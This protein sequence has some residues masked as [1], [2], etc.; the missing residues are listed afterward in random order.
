MADLRHEISIEAKPETILQAITTAAGLR[1]WWTT[2]VEAQPKEGSLAKFGFMNRAVIFT[3]KVERIHSE[4][5]EWTCVDGPADWIG[6]KQKFSFLKAEDGGTLVRF[7]HSGW[8]DDAA[9]LPRCNTTWGHLMTTLKDYAEHA[10]ANPYF[11]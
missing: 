9:S 10:K 7:V 11:K 2:D 4:G 1:S 3:M 8:K 6:T 5:V